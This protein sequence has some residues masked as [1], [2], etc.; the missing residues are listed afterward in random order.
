MAK[1]APKLIIHYISPGERT[2]QTR[3]YC[4]AEDRT[5]SVPVTSSDL[6][7]VDCL[8]CLRA[9]QA[10]WG[11]PAADRIAEVKRARARTAELLSGTAVTEVA[12]NEAREGVTNLAASEMTAPDEIDRALSEF[13]EAVREDERR[14]LRDFGALPRAVRHG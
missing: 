13:E 10:M 5:G 7:V 1:N 8:S 12:L 4:G 6:A 9:H 3:T 11:K 14:R 2:H